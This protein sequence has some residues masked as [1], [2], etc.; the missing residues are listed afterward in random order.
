MPK[1]QDGDKKEK[2]ES[3]HE[4]DNYLIIHINNRVCKMCVVVS[5]PKLV[6]GQN[7]KDQNSYPDCPFP[8]KYLISDNG[9]RVLHKCIHKN[10]LIC[11]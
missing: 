1:W 5:A 7:R 9:H 6:G 3:S 8:E 11:E 10:L 4:Q 2:H